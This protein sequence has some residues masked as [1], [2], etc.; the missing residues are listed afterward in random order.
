MGQAAEWK[1]DQQ[2]G[3]YSVFAEG[4]EQLRDIKKK[5]PLR[6]LSSDDFAHWQR[7]GYVI[8]PNAVSAEDVRRTVD[9]LWEFQDMDP[10]NPATW[11]KTELKAHE[12][13]EITGAGMV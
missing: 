8:V 6:V 7:Y 4:Y 10:A 9:F 12:M 1:K 5:L 13:K 11:D 3:N 2:P